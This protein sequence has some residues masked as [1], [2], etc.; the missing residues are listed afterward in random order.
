MAPNDHR[1]QVSRSMIG[2]GL[3]NFFPFDKGTDMSST[4]RSRG[5][6][7]AI[8]LAGGASLASAQI[9]PYG[10]GLSSS[11]GLGAPFALSPYGSAM[12]SGTGLGYTTPLLLGPNGSS[13]SGSPGFGYATAPPL[14]TYGSS[15]S[16]STGLGYAAPSPLN[17]GGVGPMANPLSPTTRY[18]LVN[19]H[20]SGCSGIDGTQYARGAGNV[21]FGSNGK[22][23]QYTA[24]G[25]PLVCN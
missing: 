12:P 20:P 14:G 1:R 16:S 6:L 18:P 8:L 4:N 25:A 7:F 2:A 13:V 23:C 19:C 15:L 24:L 22:I 5:F 9:G 21:M 11:A 10:T 3:T 17:S